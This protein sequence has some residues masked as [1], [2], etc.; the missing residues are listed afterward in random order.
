VITPE[1][2]QSVLSFEHR[3]R[4]TVTGHVD[5]LAVFDA[6]KQRPPAEMRI[7]IEASREMRAESATP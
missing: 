7:Y 5:L 4:D 6:L 3:F 2:R 1:C